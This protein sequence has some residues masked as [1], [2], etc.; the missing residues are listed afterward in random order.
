MATALCAIL[1]I[2]IA[3]LP[4][5]AS[6]VQ[7]LAAG[8]VMPTVLEPPQSPVFS[9]A[10][11]ASI[12]GRPLFAPSRRPPVRVSSVAPLPRL[13]GVV[14]TLHT[15]EAIFVSGDGSQLVLAQ[16]GHL[17]T[18]IL[19]DVGLAN[20]TLLDPS[21]NHELH[22]GVS[23]AAEISTNADHAGSFVL[24]QKPLWFHENLGDLAKERFGMNSSLTSL[25][26]VT[27]LLPDNPSTLGAAQAGTG[28]TP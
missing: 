12:L 8:D 5:G 22:V 17:G 4:K 1:L 3:Y 6:N 18:Y 21:E 15:R 16:G 25:A 10:S 19:K 13:S 23:A 26:P 20:V 7:E 24:I 2:E 28:P 27:L 9:K 11:L 14:I